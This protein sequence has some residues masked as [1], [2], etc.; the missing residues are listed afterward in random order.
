M[1]RRDVPWP[2]AVHGAGAV[3]GERHVSSVLAGVW[4]ATVPLFKLPVAALGEALTWYQP[5][6]A[7]IVIWGAV[8]A[9]SRFSARRNTPRS[10]ARSRTSGS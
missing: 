4:N 8:L 10:P 5:V 1:S 2:A 7:A 9:Q 6:G 3:L